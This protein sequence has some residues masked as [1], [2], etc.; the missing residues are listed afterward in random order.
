VAKE[1]FDCLAQAYDEDFAL[2]AVGQF[3]REQVWHQIRKLWPKHAHLLELG[4]GTGIDAQHLAEQGFQILA[5]DSSSGM[6]QEA[7]Q[8]CADL[9]QV[10]FKVLDAS[11]LDQLQ[12]TFDGAFSNFAA[13]NC[14]LDLASFAEQL[15]SRLHSGSTVA[16][17]LFGRS[18]AC[19]IAVSLLAGKPQ[20]AFRRWRSGIITAGIGKGETIE[21]RYYGISELKQIFAPWFALEKVVGIG[22]LVPPTYLQT[23]VKRWPSFFRLCNAIDKNIG[24]FWPANQFSDH[25][26]YIL[27]RRR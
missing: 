20:R 23:L 2:T 11:D 3:Q 16:L 4:C 8:R 6:L 10:S 27:R 7:Q 24:N 14:V 25:V 15:A 19:E 21:V 18:C 12:E 26:L 1:P 17:C 13:I 9:P 5:T 22:F